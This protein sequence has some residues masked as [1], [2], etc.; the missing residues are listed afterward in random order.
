VF[1][2]GA[3]RSGTTVLYRTLLQHPSFDRGPVDLTES[4][5]VLG[6][7]I[8]K[9]MDRVL[10]R[11]KH[12]MGHDDDGWEAFLRDVR[13]VRRWRGALWPV[14][15]RKIRNPAVWRVA[16]SS[17]VLRT[18][19]AYASEA[20]A[21]ARLAEKTPGN[22]PM[23][24]HLRRAFPNGRMLVIMRHPVDVLASYWRRHASDPNAPWAEISVDEFCGV[25]AESV[26]LVMSYTRKWPES[27]LLVRYEDFTA[28]PAAVFARVCAF[29][30]EP[31]VDAALVGTR[32]RFWEVEPLIFDDIR[33]GGS[34]AASV[35]EEVAT[36]VRSRLKEPMAT[37]GYDVT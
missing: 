10:V 30:G 12:Y 23:V 13:A 25:W 35:P 32:D 21:P 18:Y 4:F 9:D 29:I 5:A 3:A 24:P 36:E 2:V 31:M 16:G 37:L 11:L 7:T 26:A 15:G 28:D 1:V 17:I 8:D 20:R 34:D 22:L 6:L 33:E 27:V 19:F 14:L